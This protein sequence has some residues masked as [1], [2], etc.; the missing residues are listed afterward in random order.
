MRLEQWIRS[1]GKGNLFN[2]S[3]WTETERNPGFYYQ[4]YQLRNIQLVQQISRQIYRVIEGDWQLRDQPPNM[5]QLAR[6]LLNNEKA[7]LAI[8]PRQAAAELGWTNSA[9]L[10]NQHWFISNHR[11]CQFRLAWGFGELKIFKTCNQNLFYFTDPEIARYLLAF[12]WIRQKNTSPE[13]LQQFKSNLTPIQ[14]QY[15]YQSRRRL[16]RLIGRSLFPSNSS[17]PRS[18]S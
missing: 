13:K 1:H 11:P 15:L 9:A 12:N 16:S 18:Q 7:K 6:M 3:H 10:H 4:F 17:F 14:L 8:H 5:L 2:I